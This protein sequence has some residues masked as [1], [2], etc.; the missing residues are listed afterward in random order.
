MPRYRK[1]P[2]VVEAEQFFPGREPWPDGVESR[3]GLELPGW[4]GDPD[5]RVPIVHT[6]HQ[7]LAIPRDGD[8]IVRDASGATLVVKPDTFDQTYEPAD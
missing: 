3:M 6:E 5:A 7:G 1:K 4:F 2:V 8:W